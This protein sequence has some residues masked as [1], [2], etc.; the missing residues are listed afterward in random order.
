MHPSAMYFTAGPLAAAP[1]PAPSGRPQ[2]G[3]PPQAV[4]RAFRGPRDTLA[5]MAEHALGDYGE[6][7]MLV[8]Q[9]TEWVTRQVWPKHYLGEILA[10]RNVFV[11]PSPWV[12]HAPLF[13]YTNDP[14]H[15]EL[16]KTPERMVREI[17]ESGQT[18]VD[19]FPKGTLLL[20]DDYR[21]VPIEDIKPGDR[22]WGYDKWSTVK[23]RE[24]KGILPIDVLFLNNGSQ[25]RLTADHHVLVGTCRRHR[26]PYGG[27]MACTCSSGAFTR[28]QVRDLRPGM[29]LPVPRSIPCGGEP[30]DPA[31][32]Y[33]AGL[34]V[35]D[36]WS[37]SPYAFAI[38]G[39]DGC[40][41]ESQKREVEEIC[42]R[43]GI[44]TA[45]Y[46]KSIYV[47]DREWAE[48]LQML[49]TRAPQKQLPSLGWNEDAAAE[50]LR[51]VMA[52][53]GVNTGTDGR[54]RTFTTT[55]RQLALQVRVLLRMFGIS[56]RVSYIENHG[57]LGKNP[58]WRLSTRG[59]YASGKQGKILRV[60][61]IERDVISVP[62]YDIETDDHH[63]YLPEHDVTVQNCDET[64]VM[65]A[66]MCLQIGRKVEL[67]AMGFAP[68]SLSHVAV[69]V[70]EP[71]S[72]QMILLDGVAG[73]REREAAGRVRE[74]LTWSLD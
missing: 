39:Q 56:A 31:R 50:L 69:R 23:W 27:K 16:V 40:P 10:I 60:A 65:A 58:I 2:L 72:Q 7:S 11:Q 19:C 71:K 20:R 34:Y 74:L 70:E 24:H 36:G 25:V 15:V 62:C 32:G 51:G 3:A 22:I 64:T 61:R 52:D 66:T 49:G 53:S 17:R 42:A 45:W 21:L 55:S 48:Q 12:P 14:R 63:V 57:G 4:V 54:A 26:S 8:R 67:V 18:V 37:S 47:H 5:K 46:R 29:M 41:K 59:G 33:V 9:F 35:A 28:V 6:R 68:N 30:M 13:K 73:P 1:W 43:L 44:R 38:S